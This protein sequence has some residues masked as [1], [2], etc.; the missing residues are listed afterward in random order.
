M[1]K[2]LLLLSSLVL[3]LACNGAN[4]K[5]VKIEQTKK[6]NPPI[7][8][9]IHK[10]VKNKST[11]EDLGIKTKENP[12]QS[13]RETKSTLQEILLSIDQQQISED[14]L[15]ALFTEMLL[16]KIIPYWYQTKW[17]FAGHSEVPR[18]GEIACGYF[19]STTLRDV[20]LK[21]NRFRL[22]Q[23]APL[24]E[25][26]TLALDNPLIE[27]QKESA[28]ENIQALKDTLVEGIYFIGFDQG[29]VGYILKREEQLFLIH[30]NY[31]NNE[32]VII[33]AI[34]ESNVFS[35][36][37]RF[38]LAAISTNQAL[39]HKWLLQEEIEVQTD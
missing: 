20:G 29:H 30:S 36:F 22:A 28:L 6:I 15:S 24:V 14:S 32:G 1:I 31:L 25:A 18:Q 11:L 9:T 35:S 38:H 13:Y 23:Q 37:T 19:V 17:S 26:K 10:T 12:R 4:N 3:L 39:L 16:N 8:S 21:I 33:E 27:I 5:T 7:D 2:Q 34:A